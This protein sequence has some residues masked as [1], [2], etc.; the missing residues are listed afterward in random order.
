[1]LE[2]FLAGASDYSMLALDVRARICQGNFQSTLASQEKLAQMSYRDPLYLK[3]VSSH[4]TK[5]GKP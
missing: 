5:K 1:M 3:S 4:T 2:P